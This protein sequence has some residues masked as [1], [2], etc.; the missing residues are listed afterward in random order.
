M[1]ILGFLFGSSN[2][3][4]FSDTNSDGE[5]DDFMYRLEKDGNYTPVSRAEY[6]DETDQL[7][8]NGYY[9]EIIE[10]LD[11]PDE[12]KGSGGILGWFGL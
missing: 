8:R 1:S 2:D 4:F 3:D 12:P 5:E 9:D 11:F 10:D 7:F 6:K